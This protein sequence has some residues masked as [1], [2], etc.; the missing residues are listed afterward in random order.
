MFHNISMNLQT[1][2]KIIL[3]W[4]IDLF[5]G[6]WFLMYWLISWSG[7]MIDWYKL[8]YHD[9]LDNGINHS[10]FVRL[11]DWLICLL[12]IGFSCI[13]WFL[14]QVVWLIDFNLLIMINCMIELISWFVRLIDWLIC[15]LVIGFLCINWFLGQ[16]VWLID[17]N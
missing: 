14:G 13:D 12:V 5:V 10:W 7:C 2:T 9:Q 15:F 1:R 17:F 16:V 6:H 4:L 8:I 11:I 3:H